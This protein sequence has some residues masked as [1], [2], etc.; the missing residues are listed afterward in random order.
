MR[1]LARANLGAFLP[2]PPSFHAFGVL[3]MPWDCMGSG[4]AREWARDCGIGTSVVQGV[5]S[6]RAQLDSAP[7]LKMCCSSAI[8]ASSGD[9]TS[10]SDGMEEEQQQRNGKKKKKKVAVKPKS[11]GG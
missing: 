10:D 7:H 3:S 5:G 4:C 1:V 9:D 11:A 2:A 6:G 8:D